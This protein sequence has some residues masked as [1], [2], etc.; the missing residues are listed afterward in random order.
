MQYIPIARNVLGL[1]NDIKGS[2]TTMK[3]RREVAAGVIVTAAFWAGMPIL[4]IDVRGVDAAEGP[5][6]W[7]L[8]VPE[9][10]VFY[11]ASDAS[12]NGWGL[13]IQYQEGE[14][15][16]DEIS[17]LFLARNLSPGLDVSRW[18][19]AGSLGQVLVTDVVGAGYP[20][21][22]SGS[23]TIQYPPLYHPQYGP[24]PSEPHEAERGAWQAYRLE[25]TDFQANVEGLPRSEQ[26]AIKAWKHAEFRLMYEHRADLALASL[27]PPIRGDY[28]SAQFTCEWSLSTGW[29]GHSCDGFPASWKQSMDR[30]AKNGERAAER[31]TATLT[32]MEAA[33]T[34]QAVSEIIYAG[35]VGTPHY[36][37]TDQTSFPVYSDWNFAP[38]SP[39]AAFDGWMDS[40]PHKAIIERT[41]HGVHPS[42]ASYTNV[43]YRGGM[44][45]VHFNIRHQWIQAG[46]TWW[47]SAHPELPVLSWQGFTSKNL[48]DEFWP[49]VYGWDGMGGTTNAR[50]V[51]I[52]SNAVVGSTNSFHYQRLY[53]AD[54]AT[55]VNGSVLGP[56]VFARG[57]VIAI[58]PDSGYVLAAGWAKV[59]NEGLH[60]YRLMALCLHPDDATGADPEFPV[61]RMWWCDLPPDSVLSGNPHTIIRTKYLHTPGSWPWLD[62]ISP[63]SWRGGTSIDVGSSGLGRSSGDLKSYASMWVFDPEGNKAVCLRYSFDMALFETAPQLSQTEFSWAN[64]TL[65]DVS[66]AISLSQRSAI[67]LNF[68]LG[69]GADDFQHIAGT[70]VFCEAEF[71]HGLNNSELVVTGVSFWTHN[72]AGGFVSNEPH[73]ASELDDAHWYVNEVPAMHLGYYESAGYME[74]ENWWRRK[75]RVTPIHAFYGDDGNVKA[76]YDI[77]TN[78]TGVFRNRG[79]ISMPDTDTDFSQVALWNTTAPAVFYRGVA[80]GASVVD[81]AA[82]EALVAG[83]TLYSAEVGCHG[84]N[85]IAD[86]PVVLHASDEH[87]VFAA[88]GVDS[89]IIAASDLPAGFPFNLEPQETWGYSSAAGIETEINPSWNAADVVET[90]RA[91]VQMDV[92]MD[93]ARVHTSRHP[94]PNKF[95]LHRAWCNPWENGWRLQYAMKLSYAAPRFTAWGITGGFAEDKAGNWALCATYGVHRGAAYYRLYDRFTFTNDAGT[96]YGFMYPGDPFVASQSTSYNSAGPFNVGGFMAS[97]FADQQTLADLMA[98]PGANPRS[99]YVRVV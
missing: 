53:T 3:I 56:Y 75:A 15:G 22:K 68:S 39:Q 74:P 86:W 88:L 58:A 48:H 42:W 31:S 57:R 37:Y 87:F 73:T 27:L 40:P 59:G 97:S 76:V 54:G 13:P 11:P 18:T 85:T 83:A 81:G 65:F 28:D 92:W 30:A 20:E 8:W 69:K 24:H 19:P 29:W 79:Q 45:S 4:E 90:S 10:F 26:A 84:V 99:H 98:I 34:Q 50:T 25:F 91:V 80:L 49:R 38:Q 12:P 6:E 95:H 46:N 52:S 93:G 2:A 44:A 94:N 17:R 51:A 60:T 16:E 96:Q 43:G 14:D 72:P 70:P 9:G 71:E 61:A 67:G 63:Y 89:P 21:N 33:Y 5:T 77:E 32:S 78:M 41:D 36:E 66:A 47:K 62:P 82:C 1:L 64:E 7:G 35:L 23:E 55:A